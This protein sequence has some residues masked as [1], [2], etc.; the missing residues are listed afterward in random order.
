MIKTCNKCG[1]YGIA[2]RQSKAGK[3]YPVDV[4][5]IDSK[6]N[7]VFGTK[8][9][10]CSPNPNK[11]ILCLTCQVKYPRIAIGHK[12]DNEALAEYGCEVCDGDT[13]PAMWGYGTE[14]QRAEAERDLRD[15]TEHIR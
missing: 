11:A 9:H 14:A 6:G 5:D 1:A 3:W 12:Q 10:M 7:P 2:L 4:T 8:P 13:N 15:L